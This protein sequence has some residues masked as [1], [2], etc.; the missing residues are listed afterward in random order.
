MSYNYDN[1]TWE[2]KKGDLISLRQMSY[3]NEI[4]QESYGIIVT[5]KIER[6]DD[7]Q[8]GMFPYVWAYM[9]ESRC[10]KKIEVTHNIKIIS[11]S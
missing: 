4:E 3:E 11:H 5:D 9:F 10:K 2:I 8:V 1:V 7:G 6:E